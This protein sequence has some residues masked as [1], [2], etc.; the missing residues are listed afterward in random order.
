MIRALL[1]LDSQRHDA[2]YHGRIVADSLVGGGQVAVDRTDDRSALTCLDGF[3]VVITYAQ[4]GCLRPDQEAGLCAFVRRGGGLVTIHPEPT[5]GDVNVD[6][7]DLLGGRPAGRGPVAELKVSAAGAEHY[8]TRRLDDRFVTLDEFSPFEGLS[9]LAEV[10]LTTSWRFRDYPLAWARTYGGGRVF[11]TSLG[12]TEQT[13]RH[14]LFQRVISRAVRHAAGRSESATLGVGV[15]GYGP[16]G[17]MG[18]AHGAAVAAV[19]GLRLVAACDRSAERRSQAEVDFPGLRTYAEAAELAADPEV[20]LAI[21]VTPPDSHAPLAELLLR[22]GKHVVCEKPFCLTTAEADRLIELAAEQRRMLSVYQNRRWDRDF[23]AVQRAVQDGLIGEVF[24]LE[25]FIGGFEH[26]CSLWHSHAPISGGAAYDWGSHYIDW[27]LDLMPGRVEEVSATAHKRVWHDVTNADQI[28]IRV[29]FEDGREAEFL[30]SDVAAVRKPKW[31]LLGTRGALVA[32]WR[33][34]TLRS[35]DHSGELIERPLAVA[36]SLAEL[37]ARV[38]DGAGNLIEQR[39]PLP[40]AMANAYH[41]NLA[42]HL[43]DGEPLAVTPRQARRTIAILEAAQRSAGDG[44]R[45]VE[46]RDGG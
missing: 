3:D 35:Q 2:A 32:H 26:P 36:E 27:I 30:Q 23:R 5:G 41:R 28:R 45:P 20:D 25:S 15:V 38:Y 12:H 33:E 43:L 13:V 14:P 1:L 34:V 8:V 40:P 11:C 22:A 18:Y 24:H 42:D 39:L 44:G 6:Y 7:L 17:G 16:A 10:L 31:Y 9:D 37:T 29:R 19:P 21:I 4:T 46:L